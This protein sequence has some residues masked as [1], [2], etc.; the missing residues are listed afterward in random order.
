MRPG[1]ITHAGMNIFAPL[2]GICRG[3]ESDILN[4]FSHR[5]HY[6]SVAEVARATKRS[7]SEVSKCLTML[8][9]RGILVRAHPTSHGFAL[10]HNSPMGKVITQFAEL[11]QRLADD[12][13]NHAM[14]WE[15]R[16]ISM[17][18]VGDELAELMGTENLLLVI[19]DP[20]APVKVHKVHY[21]RHQLNREYR[22]QLDIRIG[23]PK[24]IDDLFRARGIDIHFPPR[25]PSTLG[26]HV[27]LGLPLTQA[28]SHGRV[29]G[30]T[31][32]I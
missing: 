1:G 10:L 12:I 21:M 28:L 27:A 29:N 22:L 4:H 8:D 11:P 32:G 9:A 24:E 23:T 14:T 26:N 3:V 30:G 15:P 20:G 25:S 13:A 17:V 7:R 6:A 2:L 18:L 5:P 16:P 31:G 19:H